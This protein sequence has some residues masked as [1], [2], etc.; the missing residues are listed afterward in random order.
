MEEGGIPIGITLRRELP[1]VVSDGTGGAIICWNDFQSVFH[2]LHDDYLYLQKIDA[3]GN[4][5]WGDAVKV[6]P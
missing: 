4:T 6:S 2:A 1:Q 3:E 5:L